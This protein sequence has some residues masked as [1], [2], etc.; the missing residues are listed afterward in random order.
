MAIA[1]FISLRTPPGDFTEP[2]GGALV[3]KHKRPDNPLLATTADRIC[4][5]HLVVL[6]FLSLFCDRP[7]TLT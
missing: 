1:G 7:E 6:C 5:Y 4:L 3:C 2:L